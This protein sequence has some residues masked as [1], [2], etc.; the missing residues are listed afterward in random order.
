[1]KSNHLKTTQADC[2]KKNKKVLKAGSVQQ[3]IE[4]NEHFLD[5]ILQ[6]NNP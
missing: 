5:E 2:N 4:I 6:K 1:M 3:I